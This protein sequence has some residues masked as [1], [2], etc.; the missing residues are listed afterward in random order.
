[1]CILGF[2]VAAWLAAYFSTTFVLLFIMLGI[3]GFVG[4]ISNFSGKE[5]YKQILDNIKAGDSL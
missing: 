5:K 2:A 4:F 1:L 3:S